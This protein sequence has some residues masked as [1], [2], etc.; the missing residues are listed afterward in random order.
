[1]VLMIRQ[2]EFQL[3]KMIVLDKDKEK[4]YSY[5]TNL[6]TLSEQQNNQGLPQTLKES[7]AADN[8]SMEDPGRSLPKL[9]HTTPFTS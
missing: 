3:M 5:K 2:D 4:A 9:G 7:D 1:M 8:F 6:L